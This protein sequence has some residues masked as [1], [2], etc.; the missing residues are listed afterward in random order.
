M[1]LSVFIISPS[2]TVAIHQQVNI[3]KTLREM[4]TAK[5]TEAKSR[6]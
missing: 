5:K 3:K 4:N 1:R 6:G 2:Q